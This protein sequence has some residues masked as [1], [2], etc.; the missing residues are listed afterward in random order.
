M[1]GYPQWRWDLD[2]VFVKINGRLCYLWR[3]VDH[4]GEIPTP[5]RP[6]GMRSRRSR[7]IQSAIFYFPTIRES[8]SV[9]AFGSFRLREVATSGLLYE[10]RY[11]A[12]VSS[13]EHSHDETVIHPLGIRHSVEALLDSHWLEF[14]APMPKRTSLDSVAVTEEIGG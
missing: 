2:E 10:V 7:G 13:S 14:K 12:G 3:A 4:Q 8:F 6:A 9:A 11:S 1:R 5:A